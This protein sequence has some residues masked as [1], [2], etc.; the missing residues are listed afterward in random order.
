MKLV[1]ELKNAAKE[2]NGRFLPIEDFFSLM[3]NSPTDFSQTGSSP[4]IFNRWTVP[5]WIVLRRT[6]PRADISPKGHFP[7]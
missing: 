2:A 4:K 7:D 5:R 1:K 3:G 6:V